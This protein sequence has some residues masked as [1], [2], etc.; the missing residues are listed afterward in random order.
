MPGPESS[1][2]SGDRIEDPPFVRLPGASSRSSIRTSARR[3]R[4][5]PPDPVFEHLTKL[6]FDL[7]FVAQ[8]IERALRR[9]L[10]VH[11]RPQSAVQIHRIAPELIEVGQFVLQDPVAR[12][13]P[14]VG[15]PLPIGLD[16]ELRRH[17]AGRLQTPHAERRDQPVL[18]DVP[19]LALEAGQFGEGERVDMAED[20][21]VDM[22]GR[23]QGPVAD[24]FG[25]AVDGQPARPGDA[26]RRSRST[27]VPSSRR[28]RADP[29]GSPPDH[30]V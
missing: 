1:R 24:V 12:T 9:R 29:S 22:T 7:P 19:A 13:A 6:P 11:L 28:M 2:C 21:P 16:L 17:L 18:H 15:T 30:G 20:A 23:G 25:D 3:H 14:V 8:H 10:F 27:A 5:Q 26:R 4:E